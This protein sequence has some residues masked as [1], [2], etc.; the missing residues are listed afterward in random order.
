[1]A[2]IFISYKRT[3]KDI[4]FKIKDRIE[5]A[6][7]ERCWID[8]D[9]I[10]SDAQFVGVIVNA[11]DEAEI[12]LFMYSAA[13]SKITN[14]EK[15]WTIRELSYASDENKRIVFVNIDG[16]PLTR[17]FKF[18]YG[19]KQQVNL[20]SENEIRKLISDMKRWLKIKDTTTSNKKLQKNSINVPNNNSHKNKELPQS[21]AFEFN[22]KKFYMVLSP[23][24]RYYI[25]NINAEENDF[26][27]LDSTW[28]KVGGGALL[29][30][31]AV[32]MGAITFS[33]IAYTAFKVFKWL[34]ETEDR[35]DSNNE[36]KEKDFIVNEKICQEIS[37]KTKY[38][39]ALPSEDELN[40]VDKSTHKYCIVLRIKDNP[41]LM[42]LKG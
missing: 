38:K 36:T 10:E 22:D 3:D 11:I 15:D 7:N 16:S 12:V 1:M 29:A 18:M 9:G 35:S 25:G 40:G 19:Q 5:S 42:K 23:D 21:L 30:A 20:S 24:K 2:R 26:S 37:E 31:G 17:W 28:M 41:S 33:I 4:V 13:H 6:L 8:I 39:F 32:F 27:W 34:S 14:Y